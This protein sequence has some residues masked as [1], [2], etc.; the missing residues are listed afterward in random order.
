MRCEV[1]DH[2]H[3]DDNLVMTADGYVCERCLHDE[4]VYCVDDETY[5]RNDDI[6]V[7]EN[8]GDTYSRDS[9]DDLIFETEENVYICSHCQAEMREHRVTA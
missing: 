7:C 6:V 4:Y 8:C 3:I 2:L 1:C 9:V 5:H